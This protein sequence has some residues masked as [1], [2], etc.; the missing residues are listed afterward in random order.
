[1][2]DFFHYTSDRIPFVSS[3]RGAPAL[4]YPKN[5]IATFAKTLRHT[6]SII[7]MDPHYTKDSVIILMHDPTLDRTSTGHGKISDH[8]FAEIQ[9]LN[10]KDDLG[11]VTKYKIPKLDDVILNGPKEKR[12]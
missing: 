6:W 10:L 2:K 9:Q 8:T 1:M 4:G 3:H 12:F 5:C 11:N 7:E